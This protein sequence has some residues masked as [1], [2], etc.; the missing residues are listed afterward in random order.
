MLLFVNLRPSLVY[1][2]TFF[3][4]FEAHE[5]SLSNLDLCHSVVLFLKSCYCYPFDFLTVPTSGYF[6]C[7]F[8]YL[9][10]LLSSQQLLLVPFPLCKPRRA[11]SGHVHVFLCYLCGC[12]VVRSIQ[13]VLV[14]KSNTPNDGSDLGLNISIKGLRFLNNMAVTTKNF[15]WSLRFTFYEYH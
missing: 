11:G 1:K 14:I 7:V 13:P 10:L 12:S 4:S 2:C 15:S 3:C 8:L 9:W 5:P 6:L